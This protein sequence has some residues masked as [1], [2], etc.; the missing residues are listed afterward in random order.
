[1]SNPQ[2][3]QL[4]S[5]NRY[6][7]AALNYYL[8]LTGSPYLH[9]GYWEPLPT[10]VEER[11]LFRFRAAQEAYSKKLLSF[12]PPKTQ[13]V[14]DVGCGIGGN[15]VFLLKQGLTVDGL[16]PDSFQKK[17]FLEATEGKAVFHDMKFE[18]FKTNVVYDLVLLSESSQYMA[19]I[20]IA[21][22]AAKIL[23]PGG[24]LLLADMLRS[25]KFYTDGIFSN[26]HIVEELNQSLSQ[27]GFVLVKREDISQQIAP[28]LDLAIEIFRQFGL[29]T[30]EYIGTLIKIAVPPLYALLNWAYKRWLKKAITEGLETKTIFDKHLCYEIQLWQLSA[31]K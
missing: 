8:Q 29:S 26:C 25:D 31:K 10:S 21:E 7:N 24:Y 17:K 4:S 20:D 14:L 15:A 6:Q 19:S 9:Y 5:V 30:G 2:S 22:G 3:K 27:S 12:I 11:S 18:D 1:M 16:A 13:T 28:T 23:K